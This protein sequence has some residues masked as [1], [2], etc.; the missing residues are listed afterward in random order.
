MMSRPTLQ[1]GGVP[2]RRASFARS[3]TGTCVVGSASQRS[4]FAS[5]TTRPPGMPPPHESHHLLAAVITSPLTLGGDLGKRRSAQRLA[6]IST[7]QVRGKG[8]CLDGRVGPAGGSARVFLDDL[9]SARWEGR[10]D[11]GREVEEALVA[12]EY[13]QGRLQQAASVADIAALVRQLGLQ[14]PE[15]RA[16]KGGV[17][18]QPVEA[19]FGLGADQPVKQQA[20]PCGQI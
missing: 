13:L 7:Q 17:A 8:G 15:F 18:G 16:A 11:L 1:V 2:G 20:M 4:W 12:G 6:W 14:E 3:C 19:V 5:S 9:L 10:A